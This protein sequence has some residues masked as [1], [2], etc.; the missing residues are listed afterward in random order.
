MK[1]ISGNFPVFNTFSRHTVLLC[2]Q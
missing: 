1:L 2:N